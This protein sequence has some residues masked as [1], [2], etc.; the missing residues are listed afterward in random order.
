MTESQREWYEERA[1]IYQFEALLPKEAAEDL[2]YA[3]LQFKINLDRRRD[4]NL[5]TDNQ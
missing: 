3:D 5:E 2:A 4:G 1:S